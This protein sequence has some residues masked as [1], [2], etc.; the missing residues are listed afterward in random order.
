MP[1]ITV[2]TENSTDIEL[3]Y[4]D[5][6]TG[7]PV[8]LIHGYPLERSTRGSARSARCW[9]PAT[10]S[11]PTT[12]AAS[13][14]P[15]SRPRAT[16]T[17]RSPPISTRLL[18]HLDLQR[19]RAGRVLDGHRRGHPLP[20]HATAQRGSRKAALLGAIPPFLLKTD[21][22]PEGVDGDGLRGH[23]G[24]DRG[25]PLRL[26]RRR[27]STTST[28]STIL[29]ARPDQRAGAGRPASSSRRRRRRIA[30]YACVD[31]WLTDFRAD[32]PQD[33]R[34]HAGRARHRRPDP[35]V[36]V[37]RRAAPGPDRRRPARPGRG[38]PAQHRLDASGRGQR[39]AAGL[40]GRV[41]SRRTANESF[42]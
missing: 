29:G 3:Y 27:S 5:H 24:G 1:R 7:Q 25:R 16:T 42:S 31:T 21:D 12:A 37:D 23:Q 30:T 22:N 36:R 9:P 35:A 40:P 2:G 15:A 13:A 4:E 19:R 34:P 39:R 17:T 6:G 14:S 8:V 32:L 41:T 11:S 26:L 18:E 33:R 28:T 38:R 20:R 10:A